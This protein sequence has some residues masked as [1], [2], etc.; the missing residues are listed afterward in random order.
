[1]ASAEQLTYLG[2]P[3]ASDI[4]SMRKLLISSFSEKV[5]KGYDMLVLCKRMHNR[6]VLARLYCDTHDPFNVFQIWK[7]CTE[8]SPVD[9]KLAS[10]R[11]V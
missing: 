8:S 10:F 5:R 6:L 1:M 11:K 9:E 3:I 2:L 4:E 7:T